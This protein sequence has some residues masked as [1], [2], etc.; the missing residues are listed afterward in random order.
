MSEQKNGIT[1]DRQ[2]VFTYLMNCR[3][4]LKV[5]IGAVVGRV[6]NHDYIVVH[7]APARAVSEIVGNFKMVELRS[8]GL[9]IPLTPD[10]R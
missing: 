4:M 1:N 2:A 3:L 10:P 6:V 8:D 7:D 5:S 9:L